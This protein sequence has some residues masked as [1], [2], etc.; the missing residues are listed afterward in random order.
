MPVD[1]GPWC[2]ALSTYWSMLGAPRSPVCADAG[3]ARKL[4][5]YSRSAASA[6]PNW[7]TTAQD[8]RGALGPEGTAAAGGAVTAPGC[9]PGT[10]GFAVCV[11]CV[12]T[13][14]QSEYF[15]ALLKARSRGLKFAI[16]NGRSSERL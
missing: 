11:G 16:F 13:N 8:Q 3:Y 2:W 12:G 14:F 15:V 5:V 9:A 1:T 10:P 7:S 4:F 6:S